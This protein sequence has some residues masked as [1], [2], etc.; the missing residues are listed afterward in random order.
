MTLQE[1]KTPIILWDRD[2][3]ATEWRGVIQMMTSA[4]HPVDAILVSKVA[5][6]YLWNEVIRHGGYDLLTSPIGEQETLRAI[7]LVWSY[8]ISS[9]CMPPC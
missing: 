6:D 8:W 7:R 5:D 2:L 9:M 1:T 3:P 4:P